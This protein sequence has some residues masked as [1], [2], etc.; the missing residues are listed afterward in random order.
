MEKQENS[1][2][3]TSKTLTAQEILETGRKLQEAKSTDVGRT[4]N[5][6]ADL[7]NEHPLDKRSVTKS[8]DRVPVL[9]GLRADT[10]TA[11]EY[12]KIDRKLWG[13]V[14][15]TVT[16]F[17][18]DLDDKQHAIERAKAKKMRK[19]ILKAAKSKKGL[20]VRTNTSCSEVLVRVNAKAVKEL[21]NDVGGEAQIEKDEIGTWVLSFS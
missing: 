15:S 5:A 2:T 9:C 3:E 8:E 6:L 14:H 16:E 17:V 12:K 21:I 10:L 13:L 18:R 19:K 1:G 4:F 7:L 11:E 20:H